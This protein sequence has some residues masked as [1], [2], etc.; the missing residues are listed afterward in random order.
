MAGEIAST[1]RFML[2]SKDRDNQ[3][4]LLAQG[5]PLNDRLRAVSCHE[6]TPK[7]REESGDFDPTALEFSCTTSL[8]S[9]YEAVHN[10]MVQTDGG[11]GW[12]GIP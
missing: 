8:E 2:R 9:G 12:D 3:R 4:E 11:Y 5:I 1:A 10:A 7:E 6:Q